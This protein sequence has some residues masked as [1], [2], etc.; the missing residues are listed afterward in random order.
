MNRN[1]VCIIGSGAT[2]IYLLKH[3]LI[4]THPL[5][6]TIFEASSEVGKGMPYRSDMNADYML[7]NAFSRE[8][9]CVTRTLIDW[10]EDL[11]KRELGEWELSAHELSARAFYPRLLIGE[12]LADE[13]T[14]LCE[15]FRKAGHAVS[16]RESERVVDIASATGGKINVYTDKSERI[17]TFDHV[18]IATGHV[19]PSSPRIGA[20]KLLSPWPY[21]NVT[22][23]SPCHIGVLGSS[24]SAIDVVVALGSTHGTFVEENGT[25]SWQPNATSKPLKITMVSKMGIMPEGDFYYRY[26]YVPLNIFSS[27]AVDEQVALGDDG[28]LERLFELLCRELHEADPNY[29]D[30]LGA[31]SRTIE[32]FSDAYFKRRQE[33]G[34][35]VALK[36][37]LVK[38]RQSLKQRQTIPS[39]YVLLRAHENFDRALRSLNETDWDV[40][41]KTLL[42]VFADSYA[43]VPH[44]SSAR[45][46]A[47]FDSGVLS[48]RDSGD[49]ANFKGHDNGTVSVGIGECV[50]L[51]DVMIDARGQASAGLKELP[52]PSLIETMLNTDKPIE[53]PFEI[54]LKEV[55]FS[56]IYCLALPQVLERYP[57][58]QGLA[59]VAENAN[60]V[61]TEILKGLGAT[62]AL[63]PKQRYMPPTSAWNEPA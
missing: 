15:Q 44:L 33:L 49:D 16:I 6:L 43:A 7:C 17:E 31:D 2:S 21:T 1:R 58:S 22:S 50:L 27:K 35:H 56:S 14:R 23:L 26:P 5:D 59:N 34:G 52:F 10:L 9:P 18:V 19:W 51:F 28:L 36:A 60:L 40:F 39:R 13:F 8:I 32:G 3:L 12:Y 53:A 37:D 30:Q 20:A 47:L 55:P 46:I 11:P 62:H 29:L 57:F 45:V 4:S 61:A 54:E 38:A 48:L 42:P 24:L 63:I 25:V 41:T